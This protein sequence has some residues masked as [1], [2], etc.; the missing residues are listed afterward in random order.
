MEERLLQYFDLGWLVQFLLLFLIHTNETMVH[1]E[2][3]IF[4]LKSQFHVFNFPAHTC[5]C[6]K[7]DEAK[8]EAEEMAGNEK[9]RKGEHEFETKN[10][11]T[12][13]TFFD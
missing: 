10:R 6:L 12:T 2:S 7:N 3:L 4:V 8:V 13:F 9:S 11:Q 5:L 1:Q